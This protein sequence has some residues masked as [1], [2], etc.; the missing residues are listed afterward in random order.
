V[1]RRN[2]TYRDNVASAMENGWVDPA[3]VWGGEWVGPKE[4]C[5][6][7]ARKLAPPGKYGSTI[8][9]GGYEWDCHQGWWCGLFP[10]YFR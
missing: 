9:H 8:V 4:S 7:W 5:I 1:G 6:R 10:N 2:V 3:A